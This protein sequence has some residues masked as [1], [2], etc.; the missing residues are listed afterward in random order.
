MPT[1]KKTVSVSWQVDLEVDLELPEDEQDD[2]CEREIAY[3]AVD[4]AIYNNLAFISVSGRQVD[5]VRVH[6]DGH[7]WTKVRLKE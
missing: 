2:A 3:E 5:E 6:V 1:V 7:G 4:Q